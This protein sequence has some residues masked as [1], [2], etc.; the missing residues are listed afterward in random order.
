MH[1]PNGYLSDPICAL[2]GATAAGALGLSVARIRRAGNSGACNWM[3]VT[4]AGIFAAQMINFSVDHGTSGHML[5]AALAAITVGPWAAMI[6]MTLVLVAQCFLF[7]DGGLTALGANTLNMAVVATL[8]ASAIYAAVGRFAQARGKWLPAALAAFGSV[9]AAALMCS[10]ELAASGTQP[11][12]QVLPAVMLAHLPIAGGEAL[13]TLAVLAALAGAGVQLPV[14]AQ[15]PTARRRFVVA[16]LALAVAVAV[17]LSPLSSTLP[18]GLERTAEDLGF[19]N[20]A[21]GNLLPSFADYSMPGIAWPV[22][23]TGLAG[24]LGVITV[25]ITTLAASR[26]ATSKVRKH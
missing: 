5:G 26:A 13:I 24:S 6:T 20:L 4:G 1:I 23:A 10:L 15:Q 25:F 3:A 2:T 16:G 17:L 22:L 11:L 12:S 9:L 21:S 8:S 14:T 19:A 18:D 7:G